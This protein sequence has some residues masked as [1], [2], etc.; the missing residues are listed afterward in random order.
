M[1]NPT[2]IWPISDFEVVNS[3]IIRQ[4][5][6]VNPLSGGK[7]QRISNELQ[8]VS[9]SDGTGVSTIH[10]GIHFFTIQIKQL[11]F[12]VN[13]SPTNANIDNSVRGLLNFNRDLFWDGVTIVFK[14]FWIY[15]PQEHEQGKTG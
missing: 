11:Q 8:R 15:N 4:A 14:C 6:H 7:K 3:A 2:K 10:S 5:V 12:P 1:A 13:V 9:R